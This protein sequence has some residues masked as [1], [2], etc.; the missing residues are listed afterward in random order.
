MTSGSS[1]FPFQ[2]WGV[3][4]FSDATCKNFHFWPFLSFDKFKVFSVSK[5][6]SCCLMVFAAD[7]NWRQHRQPCFRPRKHHHRILAVTSR[8]AGS[9]LHVPFSFSL[10]A[11]HCR[12]QWRSQG[13]VPAC[14]H[15]ASRSHIPAKKI[16]LLSGFAHVLL[17]TSISCSIAEDIPESIFSRSCRHMLEP[18]WKISSG[19]GSVHWRARMEH[20]RSLV[21]AKSDLM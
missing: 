11:K 18:F 3:Y 4:K 12:C 16:H 19:Q 15:S 14:N 8:L 5:V 20:W 13:F 17:T 1:C 9:A 21:L 2:K 6:T 10:I 7:L